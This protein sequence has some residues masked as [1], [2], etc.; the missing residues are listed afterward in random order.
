[1]ANEIL[2]VAGEASADLHAAH[3]VSELRRRDP[4]LSFFG[5]GGRALAEQ[6]VR[7][8]VPAERLNV[9]GIADWRDRL[10]EVLGAYR[11]VKAEVRRCRPRVAIL[12]DLPDFNLRLAKFLK[13]QGVSVA[14][15]ISPQ[16]WAWRRYRVHTIRKYVDKMLVVFPFE[17][18]F[19]EAAGVEAV[20]VGHP[21]L[22]MLAPRGAARSQDAIAAA[23]R[24]ALL[25]GSRLSELGYHAALLEAL[26][27]KLVAA[28]PTAEIRIPVASTL[29][30][31]MVR[32]RIP[33]PRISL[34]AD[35]REVLAWAD[36]ACVAS[37]TATLETALIGTPFCL[38]YRL[39]RTSTWILKHLIRYRRFFGMPNI[40]LGREV[41]REFLLEKATPDALFQECRWLLEKAAY[42]EG[43]G[44]ELSRCRTLLGETGASA[45]AA[46]EVSELLKRQSPSEARLV[47]SMA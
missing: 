32:A 31:S 10:K 26:C 42:R 23:P 9:V 43:L 14:Y 47:P 4:S 8:H 33:H 28:Y 27:E 46:K 25:P 16:V 2:I 21:L 1:M 35:S 37:G 13:S 22:E 17:K 12:L 38:F 39:G 29:D 36:I 7:I 34:H 11:S 30:E 19:Y 45:R 15:Y 5:V 20:F 44:A 6:G 18:A 24:I 3:L 40:L 41:V